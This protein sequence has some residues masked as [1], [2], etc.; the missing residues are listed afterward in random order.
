MREYE[1]GCG[2][3]ARGAAMTN[4]ERRLVL[5]VGPHKTASTYIQENLKRS[6]SS[7]AKQGWL[8]S[9]VGKKA[10]EAGHHDLAHNPDTYLAADAPHRRK[11]QGLGERAARKGA[12]V[13]FSAEGLCRWEPPRFATLAGI[14]GFQAYE[15]AYVIRDP[16]DLF[17]SFW[18]EEVKQG[19][20]AGF[21]ERFAREFSDPV[22]SR[23]FNPLHDLLPFLPRPQAPQRA[24]VHAI[25][26]DLLRSRELDIFE[27]F[28][29]QVLGVEGVS[30][31]HRKQANVKYPV[32][33]T[34]FLRV[35]NLLHGQGETNIGSDLRLRFTASVSPAEQRELA[36]LVRKNAQ[37]ARRV[38]T[39]PGDA[40]FMRAIQNQLRNRLQESWTLA[41]PQDA[42]LYREEPR[43]FVY[44]ETYLLATNPAVRKAA[45]D[46]LVRLS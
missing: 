30:A 12:N 46:M 16:L 5:H 41:P 2:I 36:Q 23:I 8:Y 13:V 34:E 1:S 32:E 29:S 43:K 14:L 35:L 11:L 17:P 4:N 28:V 40:T 18:G 33:L 19:R 25:P 39:V 38:I 37:N 24:R 44:Y 9:D 42:P 45:D 20:W 7:L 21:A 31:A 27:H 10:F 26:Y 3:D 15:I 6:C 22:R